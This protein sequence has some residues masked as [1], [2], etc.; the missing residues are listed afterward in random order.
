MHRVYL[1]A[2]LSITI[3]FTLLC[4]FFFIVPT[5][6]PPFLTFQ[7]AWQLLDTA[8]VLYSKS[9]PSDLTAQLALADAHEG[10]GNVQ[11]EN[12]TLLN[13]RSNA[14]CRKNRQSALS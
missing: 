6:G 14:L 13:R 12:G 10:M 8:R 4:V 7:L 9:A 11:M 3:F 1:F 5:L 2:S